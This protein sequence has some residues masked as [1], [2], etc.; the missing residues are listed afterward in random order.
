[1]TTPHKV[2]QGEELI[3]MNTLGMAKQAG[4]SPLFSKD[5]EQWAL[6]GNENIEAFAKLVAEQAVAE[7]KARLVPVEIKTKENE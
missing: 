4:A 6:T 2:E 1:M 3:I 5:I 7:Y